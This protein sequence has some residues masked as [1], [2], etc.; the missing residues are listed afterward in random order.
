MNLEDRLENEAIRFC[1]TLR[2]HSTGELLVAWEF[3]SESDA[4]QCTYVLRVPMDWIDS[5]PGCGTCDLLIE[6]G[7]T[8]ELAQIDTATEEHRVSTIKELT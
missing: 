6:K 1:V 7:A 4:Q 5:H 2:S 3:T 8:D